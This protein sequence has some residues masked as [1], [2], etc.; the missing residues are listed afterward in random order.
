[1]VHGRVALAQTVAVVAEQVRAAVLQRQPKLSV[2]D[3]LVD[4]HPL[5]R[6]AA[7]RLKRRDG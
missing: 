7:S 3:E 2:P 5:V 6:A 1:M 4:P